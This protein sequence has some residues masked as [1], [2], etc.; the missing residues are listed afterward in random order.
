M[1]DGPV[2]T[3]RDRM[4]TPLF[5]DRRQAGALL[6]VKLGNYRDRPDVLVL[7]LPRGGV[8]VAYEVSRSLHTP[9]DLSEVN[10][11]VCVVTPEPFYAVGLWYEDFSPTTDGEIHGLLE[12]ADRERSGLRGR[13]G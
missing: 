9:L 12:D 10:E 5:R 11:T 2:S 13:R 8:P 6:A 7:A 3:T 4:H 1:S